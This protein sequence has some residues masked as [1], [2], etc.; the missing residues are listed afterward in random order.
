LGGGVSPLWIAFGCAAENVLITLEQI[1][2]DG[3]CRIDDAVVISWRPRLAPPPDPRLHRMIPLRRTSRRPFG[4][5]EPIQAEGVEWLTADQRPLVRRQM[6]ADLSDPATAREMYRWL[7]LLPGPHRDGLTAECLGLRPW[8]ARVAAVLTHPWLPAWLRRLLLDDVSPSPLWGVLH[9]GSQDAEGWFAAGRRLQRLWLEATA[10]G[11][12]L[13]PV[14]A[15][16]EPPACL[17]FRFGTSPSVP[18]APRLP[19]DELLE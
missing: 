19:A 4:P 11:L 18:A 8:E 17:M 9:A 14:R 12:Y 2:F 15:A 7:R 5:A 6:L 10:R 3:E 16:L 13:H 1:S